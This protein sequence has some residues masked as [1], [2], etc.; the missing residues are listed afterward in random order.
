MNASGPK[1]DWR[2]LAARDDLADERLR[3]TVT[4]A[5]FT[6]G[7][8]ARI[9]APV[10]PLR[11][12]PDPA[13]PRDTEALH[14]EPMKVF[15]EAGGWAWVQLEVDGYVGYVEQSALARDLD[16]APTHRIKSRSAVVYETASAL[17]EP[18]AILP[19][20]AIVAVIGGDDKFAALASGGHVG[21]CL[22]APCDEPAS[23]YVA[24]AESFLG[25]PYIY[26][27]KSHIG[28]D[29]SG[30]VQMSL[31]AAGIAAPRDS[32]MQ[33][34]ELGEPVVIGEDL[35]G[36]RRGDLV[37]WPGHAAIMVSATD[38]VHAT[39][40]WVRTVREPLGIVAD[41]ARNDGPRVAAVRRLP[42]A[43][44]DQ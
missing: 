6:E 27:G 1:L 33:A 14:G 15:E 5:R 12:S 11:R 39:A 10:T 7:R 26:G 2:R 22:L 9:S 31:L 41:R 16:P 13:A 29:C 3:G 24:V 25:T 19:M 35:G 20:N 23:D 30:L 18:R 32:D 38:V 17:S 28:I 34:A 21:R 40:A 4:A 44:L 42:G 8:P 43:K 36:L 37:F